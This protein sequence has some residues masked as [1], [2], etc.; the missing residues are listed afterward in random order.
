MLLTDIQLS[1][2]LDI[3]N[4][5]VVGNPRPRYVFKDGQVTDDINGY[6][7]PV[8]DGKFL[9]SVFVAGGRRNLGTYQ[10]VKLINPSFTYVAKNREVMA[11]SDDIRGLKNE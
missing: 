7:Y 3:D 9:Q 11:S 5:V 6:V 4:L 1:N 8:S 2:V 10:R